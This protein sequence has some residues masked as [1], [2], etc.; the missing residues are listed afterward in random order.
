MLASTP[1]FTFVL[2]LTLALGI[3]ANAVIFT[4]VDAVLLQRAPVA[5]PETLV[6]VY[7]GASS[8]RDPFSQLLVPGFCGPARQRGRRGP[9]RLRVDR[10]R[11]RQR[12]NDRAVVGELVSGNYFDLLGVTMPMGRGFRADED[13]P[14]A[15]VRVVVISHGAWMNRFG[16][17]PAI[18]G[19][20]ASSQRPDLHRSSASPHA[21]SPGRCSDALPEMWAPMA[22]QPELRPPSAGVRRTL[23]GSNLL[24]VRGTRW[25]NLIG[26]LREPVGIAGDPRRSTRSQRTP[27]SSSIRESNRGRRYN[28]VP[29]GEGPGVRASAR[30]LLQLLSGGGRPGPADRLRQRRRAPDG[31]GG[32]PAS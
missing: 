23:G 20:T 13:V 28:V 5:H 1:G 26:R 24:T 25:L 21:D 3:G 29:F 22:L 27:G 30:P 18:V 2:C 16:S 7:T 14:G 11:P 31:A 10:A 12:R 32:E 8:G 4:A 9:R 19:R 17:D 6:S 15:P